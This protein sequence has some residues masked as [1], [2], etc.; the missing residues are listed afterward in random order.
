MY[1]VLLGIFIVVLLGF[2]WYVVWLGVCDRGGF[3]FLFFIFWWVCWCVLAG[4]CV[5]CV[6]L[7]ILVGRLFYG[8][9][10]LLF[11]GFLICWFCS[12]LLGVVDVWYWLLL[13]LLC[14][15]GRCYWYRRGKVWEFWC[16]WGRCNW[17]CC[18]GC[19]VNMGVGFWC[20]WL[21][22]CSGWC[23]AVLVGVDGDSI[24]IN[25]SCFWWW[26]LWYC[27]YWVWLGVCWWSWSLILG[28]WVIWVCRLVRVYGGWW[29]WWWFVLWVVCCV[30]VCV[31]CW[32][33]LVWLWFVCRRFY[34]WWLGVWDRRC[35]WLGWYLVRFL[36]I[37]YVVRRL[38]VL[39]VVALLSDWNCVFLLGRWNF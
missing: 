9:L 7:M 4:G 23:W 21:V 37:G 2:C 32:F 3:L 16:C 20:L 22:C 24:V 13:A 26:L 1:L 12:V 36:V 27:G 33:G 28:C 38:V 30:V 14:G 11:W 34:W 6:V 25:C 31:C 35:G 29:S 17:V 15:L 8:F 39:Y 18:C 5:F 19:S 10:V